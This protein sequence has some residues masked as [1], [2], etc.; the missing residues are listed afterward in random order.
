[1]RTVGFRDS[2]TW[3]GYSKKNSHPFTKPPGD[4]FRKSAYLFPLQ[5]GWGP[6]KKKKMFLGIVVCWS[7]SLFCLEKKRTTRKDV[8]N[9][10]SDHRVLFITTCFGSY[11]NGF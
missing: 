1:M 11:K 8:A 5:T 3:G 7:Y 6:K 2:K 4:D 9:K 10:G